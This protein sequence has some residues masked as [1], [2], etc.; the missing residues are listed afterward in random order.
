MLITDLTAIQKAIEN[1]SEPA[2]EIILGHEKAKIIRKWADLAT[3]GKRHI[4]QMRMNTAN[5]DW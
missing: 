4:P 1:T 2:N 5:P 3:E